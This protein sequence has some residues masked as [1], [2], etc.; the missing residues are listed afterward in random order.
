[1]NNKLLL[2]R[3]VNLQNQYINFLNFIHPNFEFVDDLSLYENPDPIGIIYTGQYSDDLQERLNSITDKWIIVNSHNFDLDLTTTEGLIK[4]LLPV[5]YY[6]IKNSKDDDISVYTNVSYDS[7][8]EKVKLCLI[9]N[10]LLEINSEADS[11]VYNLF[12]AILS[13]PDVLNSVYFNLVNKNN[14]SVMTSA[15]LSFL[16]KVQSK[17]IRGAKV[18]YA[19]L[20]T[21][22]N[23]RY[24][25]VIKRAI[26][27]FVRSKNCKEIALHKLL[28]ELNRAR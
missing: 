19:R 18:H 20:I 14:V 22:S 27:N 21:Q 2:K 1:M 5:N 12:A 4:N 7:M 26:L 17:N 13:T 24:G 3:R 23:Q 10:S 11:S 16:N 25:K 9:T 8:L 28:L 6:K 15:I